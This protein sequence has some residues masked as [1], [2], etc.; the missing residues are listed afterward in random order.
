MAE[1]TWSANVKKALI[2]SMCLSYMSYSFNL[3]YVFVLQ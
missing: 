3:Q 2:Y 1:A